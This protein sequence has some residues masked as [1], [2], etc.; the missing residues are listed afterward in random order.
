MR[1]CTAEAEFR[2]L[3]CRIWCLRGNLELKSEFPWG[4][5]AGWDAQAGARHSGI[6]WWSR[7]V[8]W[9]K[10]QL[11]C[12]EIRKSSIIFVPYRTK[13]NQSGFTHCFNF[14]CCFVWFG[15]GKGENGAKLQT[16][17]LSCWGKSRDPFHSNECPS[18]S[19]TKTNFPLPPTEEEQEETFPSQSRITNSKWCALGS[20]QAPPG[21]FYA[22]NVFS[23]LGPSG[24]V[25][26]PLS[27]QLMLAGISQEQLLPL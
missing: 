13:A 11:E 5:R 23:V 9:W 16:A 8:K 14:W 22:E 2:I 21:Y 17:G 25:P 4:L 18:G 1:L 12:K 19:S 20:F 6:S 10:T 15:L 7:Q 26:A 24:K 27:V 3:Q